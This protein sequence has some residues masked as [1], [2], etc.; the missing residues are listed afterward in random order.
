MPTSKETNNNKHNHDDDNG[1]TIHN[2]VGWHSDYCCVFS[3]DK[4]DNTSKK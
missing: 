3:V 2:A 4:Q 1:D